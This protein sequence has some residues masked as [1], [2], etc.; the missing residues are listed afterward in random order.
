MTFGFGGAGQV[1]ENQG[2]RSELKYSWAQIRDQ[3]ALIDV[4]LSVLQLAA[5]KVAIPDPLL[6]ALRAAGALSEEAAGLAAL[7]GST[8]PHALR[9]AIDLARLVLLG[10]RA[11]E[12]PAADAVP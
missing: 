11:E 1:L 9:A 7:V 12:P 4:A 3:Q 8:R 2:L 6:G 5:A 10:S